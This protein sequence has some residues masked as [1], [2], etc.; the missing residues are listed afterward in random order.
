M[1]TPVRVGLPYL[2]FCVIEVLVDR[3]HDNGAAFCKGV[4]VA[5]EVGIES[6]VQKGTPGVDVWLVQHE[7]CVY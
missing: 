2:G 6:A 1:Q 4:K 3:V 5:T 7:C